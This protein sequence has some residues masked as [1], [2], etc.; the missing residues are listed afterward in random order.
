MLDV[1]MLFEIEDLKDLNNLT[2][3]GV[4]KLE[5]QSGVHGVL[6]RRVPWLR[7]LTLSGPLHAIASKPYCLFSVTTSIVLTCDIA[8][9][10]IMQPDK[11][12]EVEL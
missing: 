6:S 8:N 2:R 4:A 3:H 9:P 5:R 11:Y 1:S 12:H 10:G 7:Y